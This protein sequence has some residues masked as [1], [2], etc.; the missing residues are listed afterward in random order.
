MNLGLITLPPFCESSSS[1]KTIPYLPNLLTSFNAFIVSAPSRFR[2]TCG[3]INF[4]YPLGG[5]RNSLVEIM[6]W[7][8]KGNI[9]SLSLFE[10]L[11]LISTSLLMGSLRF[12]FLN[13]VASSLLVLSII[14]SLFD[15]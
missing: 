8:G 2:V 9:F 1:R 6:L 15:S 11:L 7:E 3:P 13:R 5:T 12:L 14:T 4:I 10:F